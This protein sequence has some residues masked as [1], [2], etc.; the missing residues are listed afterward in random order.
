MREHRSVLSAGSLTSDP[1]KNASGDKIADVKEIMVDLR[2]GNV[3]YVVVAYGGLMGMGEKLFA[4]PWDAVRVDQE[5]KAIVLDLD[6]EVL[7]TAPGFDPQHWP[8]WSDPAWTQS[9]R[10]HYGLN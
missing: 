5:D 9:I 2:D 10:T 7:K 8:D 4:V 3:A 6:E 1:V